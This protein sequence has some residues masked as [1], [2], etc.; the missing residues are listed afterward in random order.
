MIPS[1]LDGH[2][3]TRIGKETFE[4]CTN[5]T[6]LVIPA[7]VTS[8]E[9]NTF[10]F[11]MYSYLG[12]ID[13]SPDNP[14]YEEI[15]GVLFDKH[16]KAL[17]KYP[18]GKGAQA[19]AIPEGVTQIGENAFLYCR[20]LTSITI[21]D[22]VI[23]IGNGAFTSCTQ[24]T[25]VTI[26]YGVK[27]IGD[28]AFSSC[29]QL[30]D[31]TIPD[32]VSRIGSFAFSRC[33]LTSI[34][35]PDSVISIGKA[36][37]YDCIEMTR[38][39][40][41][42]SVTEIEG[43][44][45]LN[46]RGPFITFID[47]APNNPRYEQIDGVLFDK[48]KKTLVAYPSARAGG[49]VIPEGV[50]RIGDEAFA[51]CWEL[52]SIT[53]PDSIRSIGKLAF[54]SCKQLTDITIP[55]GVEHIGIGAFSGCRGLTRLM[56]PASVTSLEAIQ[57]SPE[58]PSGTGIVFID[59]SPDNPRYTQINGVLFDKMEKV[60]VSYPDGRKGGYEIPEGVAHI[61]DYAFTSARLVSL[62][63][64][65]SVIDIGDRAFEYCWSLTSV[66]IPSSVTA[67]GEYPFASCNA[68]LTLNVIQGSMA[69]QHA[70]DNDIAFIATK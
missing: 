10:D 35:I 14:R 69:E 16:E 40:I 11:D 60:L 70:K 23:D 53:I 36:A 58:E 50:Q 8:I 24:L 1:E 33:A 3:V 18:A 62:T 27:S 17:V 13:V 59:V 12:F 54:Q 34:T 67:I 37:F 28:R 56:I 47:V 9:A 49:Y 29:V 48:L 32:S 19:Y 39:L 46:H 65:D 15:D 38:V 45:F 41:P 31:V 44:L 43:N 42:A 4:L 68:K 30:A 25:N 20:Y 66:T 6:R 63:I 26:T 7:S 21:P 22:S 52:T 57:F 2:A 64:P 5:L 61:G 55:E 51:T